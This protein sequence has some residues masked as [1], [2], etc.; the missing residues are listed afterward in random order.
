MEHL[1]LYIFGGFIVFFCLF[2]IKTL[3]DLNKTLKNETSQNT[4]TGNSVQRLQASI[5]S[6]NLSFALITG[7]IVVGLTV[8]YR[9]HNTPKT[10][11][12]VSEAV[13]IEETPKP[14]GAALDLAT[15]T[16]LIDAPSL[17][18]GAETF[19]NLCAACHGQS[20]E[21]MVG[22]NFADKFW[23]HGG[24]FKDLCKVI[25]EGVP[26]KGMISWAGQLS[27]DQIKQV[28]SYILSLEGSNP[29]NQK[30]AQGTAFE[31]KEPINFAIRPAATAAVNIPK[32]GL[33]GNKK[34]GQKLFDGM[35]GC[36]HCHGT[37]AVGHVDNRNLRALKKRYAADASKV[38]DT[39]MEIGRLGTAMPPW[40]H[41]TMG[42]KQ[43]I[44]T[45]IFS[46][47]E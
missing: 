17:K 37:G 40:P 3:R 24:E 45:F 1:T 38:Y 27:G 34:Q 33:K 30:A 14:T 13:A 46:I 44:K 26:E 20:G 18:A 11:P 15:A 9:Q 23:L 22:P 21:G 10:P 31:R 35:L 43:D 39:V 2:A 47:Q 36:S 42:Q 8:F 7:L 5:A 4:E 19:K 29:P 25:V 16:V 6:G 28:A 41:L 32:I 12:S